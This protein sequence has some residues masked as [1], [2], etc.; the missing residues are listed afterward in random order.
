[1]Q[2][3]VTLNEVFSLAQKLSPRDKLRLIEHIAPEIERDLNSVQSEPR[4]SL[5]GL[6]AGLGPALSA[7]EIDEARVRVGR[8]ALDRDV[9]L[10]TGGPHVGR[11]REMPGAGVVLLG[12]GRR[13]GPEDQQGGAEQTGESRSHHVGVSSLAA[14]GRSREAGRPP[15]ER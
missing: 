13:G 11:E 8:H 1:M 2:N 12:A 9:A 5:W 7:E 14:P 15:S 3:T 6:W 10:D 4:Q